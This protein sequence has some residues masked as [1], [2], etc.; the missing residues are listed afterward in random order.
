[1]D[2]VRTPIS[3][4][5]PDLCNGV[6]DGNPQSQNQKRRIEHATTATVNNDRY[7]TICRL[8]L[9]PTKDDTA[10]A[11]NTIYRR[12]FDSTKEIDDTA[13]I[14]TLEQL[15]IKHGKD[16]P[17]EKDYKTV[18]TDWRKCHV[19]KREYVSFQLESTQKISQLK[20]GSIANGNKGIFDTLRSNSAFLRMRKYGSQTEASIGFFLG[21]NPKITLRKAL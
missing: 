6:R 16:M 11:T 7:T 5:P 2:D 19:T 9:R 8:E 18:F 14:I 12:I 3:Q 4:E 20:Y 17:T 10:T 1:M 13:V 15:R 21:I